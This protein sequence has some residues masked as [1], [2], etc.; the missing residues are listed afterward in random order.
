MAAWR[1][2]TKRPKGKP[3]PN[4]VWVLLIVAEGVIA[5]VALKLS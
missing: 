5:L 2:V 3:W 1:E 4:W